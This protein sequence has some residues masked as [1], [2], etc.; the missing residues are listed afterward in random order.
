M[1]VAADPGA[2][3]MAKSICPVATGEQIIVCADP[4]DRS[5]YRIDPALAAVQR[6]AGDLGADPLMQRDIGKE[7]CLP[8][9][10]KPCPGLDTIPV[11]AIARVAAQ[12]AILA[13]GGEDWRA[14]LRTEADHY[15][16]YREAKAK[17]ER[18]KSDRKVRFG[19]FSKR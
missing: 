8:H 19:I 3:V 12:S 6:Q 14:P 9:G 11:L 4:A 7:G 17:E 5:G 18:R 16:V 15:E 13:A 1:L 2:K 10:L